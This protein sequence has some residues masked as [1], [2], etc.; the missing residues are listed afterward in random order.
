MDD[1]GAR[2]VPPPVQLVEDIADVGRHYKRE[3]KTEGTRRERLWSFVSRQLKGHEIAEFN[4]CSNS[5]VHVKDSARMAFVMRFCCSRDA[6]QL[7][8]VSSPC[9][10][11][12][13]TGRGKIIDVLA[14]GI[15]ANNGCVIEA[16]LC[17]QTRG[18]KDGLLEYYQSSLDQ[19]IM[20]PRIFFLL[21]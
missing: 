13:A 5:S 18:L 20:P 10:G 7:S 1:K 19:D 15:A 21:S 4:L 16:V 17:H 12:T 6:H 2:S 9:R 11:A 8:A 14:W 3:L